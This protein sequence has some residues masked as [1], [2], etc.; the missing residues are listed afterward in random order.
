MEF[1]VARRRRPSTRPLPRRREGNVLISIS[2]M[3]FLTWYDFISF[4]FILSF[5]FLS[6]HFVVFH[7]HF[8]QFFGC[9]LI[10]VQLLA[11]CFKEGGEHMLESYRLEVAS[12][13]R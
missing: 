7:F 13:G 4:P 11:M 3:L 12:S 10:I 6:F 8:L 2:L 1:D 5:P 9:F